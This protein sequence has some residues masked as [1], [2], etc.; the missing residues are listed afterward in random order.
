MLDKDKLINHLQKSRNKI[1]EAKPEHFTVLQDAIID[2]SVKVIDE[3]IVQIES[4]RF[5]KEE[6]DR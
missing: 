3:I 2:T 5:D 1:L 4:G 6:N